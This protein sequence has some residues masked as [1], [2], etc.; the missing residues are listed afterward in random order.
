MG[1]VKAVIS[2]GFY[3]EIRK[4]YGVGAGFGAMKGEILHFKCEKCGK[5]AYFALKPRF[6]LV[7]STKKEV[8]T[9]L[10]SLF[11]TY[12]TKESHK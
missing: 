5:R 6:F 1:L 10:S 4:K 12:H 7:I 8:F 3:T 9:P 11:S 2:A